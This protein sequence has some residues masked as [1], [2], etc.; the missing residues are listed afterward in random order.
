QIEDGSGERPSK[1]GK[2][3]ITAGRGVAPLAIHDPSKVRVTTAKNVNAKE[4]RGTEARTNRENDFGVRLESEGGLITH[5]RTIKNV[6]WRRRG[7]VSVGAL[8]GSAQG[9]G[10]QIPSRNGN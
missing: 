1:V 2:R 6:A 3:R 9:L 7:P 8:I 10:T 4:K 5:W